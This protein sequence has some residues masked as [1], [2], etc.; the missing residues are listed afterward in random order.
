MM[1][2]QPPHEPELSSKV[3]LKSNPVKLNVS[4]E[5]KRKGKSDDVKDDVPL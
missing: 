5:G 3:P 2:N 4:E 1:I